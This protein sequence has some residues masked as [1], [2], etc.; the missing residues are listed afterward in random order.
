MNPLH[1]AAFF[2]TAASAADLSFPSA[3]EVAFVGRSNSGKSSA[4]NTLANRRQLAFSSKTPG[5]TQ[6]INFFAVGEDR[7]LVDLPGYGY[8]KVQKSERRRWM[9]F[10]G[11]YLQTRE[12]LAGLVLI[13]DARHPLTELDRQLLQWFLP[14]AIPVHVLL[15]KADK[16]IRSEQTRTLREVRAA[17]AEFG[18]MCSASLFSS[19]A[20]S[21]TAEAAGVIEGWLGLADAPRATPAP[22][23]GRASK[24]QGLESPT[25]GARR[26]S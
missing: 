19:L 17:L 1:R 3:A 11:S 14:R 26:P 20:K 24:G 7:F 5:R 16:L 15:T 12:P 22:A 8:A 21:G 4:I 2:T 18:D 13:M 23:S 25:S 9:G 6:Q 10:L